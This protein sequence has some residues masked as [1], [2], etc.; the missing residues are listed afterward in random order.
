SQ[1]QESPSMAGNNREDG[2]GEGQG[3]TREEP[4]QLRGGGS[5]GSSLAQSWRN[6][7]T[8]GEGG[9]N[10]DQG[11]MGGNS[12]RE[13]T[14]GLREAEEMV[15]VPELQNDIAAIRDRART[16]RREARDAGEEPKWDLVQLQIEKPL[17]EVRKRVQ[18]EL[19]KRTSK[20][21]IVPVDRDPVPDAYSD[22][23]RTYYETLGEGR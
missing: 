6:Q 9:S 14:D 23:V 13:W 3:N 7:G 4:Q 11:P 10:Q 17:Y 2:Q 1:G 19:S 5:G 21:A 12:F 20:E 16:I 18:E 8:G 15:D 22:L